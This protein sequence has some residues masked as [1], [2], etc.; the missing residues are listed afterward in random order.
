MTP[1]QWRHVRELF[2]AALDQKAGDAADWVKRTTAND[3]VVQTEVL[4]LLE[5]HERAGSFLIEPVVQRVPELLAGEEPLVPGTTVGSYTILREL[6]RGGMGCVYLAS[7]GKLGRKVALKAL[8]PH[9]TRDAAHRERLRREARAAAALTHPGICTVYALEEV[10][11][12]LYIATEFVDGHTLREEISSARRPS[13]EMIVASAR[14]LAAALASAHAKGIVH[15]DLKPE[16]VMRTADGRLKILDFGLA[17]QEVPASAPSPRA[18]ATVPGM[19]IGTPAYMAPEQ[20]NGEPTDARTDVFA[21]GV[22]MYEY[23]CGVHPFAASTDLALLARVL[24]SNARPLEERCPQVPGVL[25]YVIDRCLLKSPGDRFASC[26]EVLEAIGRDVTTGPLR[27]SMTWWRTHQLAVMCLYVIAATIAWEIKESVGG[28][29]ALWL[30]VVIGIGAAIG[31]IVRGHL[32]FT[33]RMNRP[34]LS[35]ERQR[36]QPVTIGAD[37]LIAATLFADGLLNAAMRPLGAVLTIALAVGIALAAMMMEPAT[38]AMALGEPGTR[39]VR[40]ARH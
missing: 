34:L 13:S 27:R 36:T 10:G 7:D 11:D 39:N 21:L 30:F 35:S 37:L 22:V 33:E 26:G 19:L 32:L 24:E 12:D 31:G 17:R 29:L 38:T 9:L 25:A 8:A 5:H 3:E 23:A 16:N 6:G 2:E 40:D 28:L 14:E 4:S 20:I 1:E 15:R 18:L